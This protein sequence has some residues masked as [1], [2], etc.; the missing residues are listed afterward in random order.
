MKQLARLSALFL[1]AIYAAP[2][3]AD[4][5]A[6]APG[7]WAGFVDGFMALLKLLAS[8]LIQVALVDAGAHALA[9]DIGYYGGVLTFAASAAAA[10]SSTENEPGT[11]EMGIARNPRHGLGMALPQGQNRAPLHLQKSRQELQTAFNSRKTAAAGTAA[12]WSRQGRSG[13]SG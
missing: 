7:F 10:A 2:A 9:Y 1:F 3:L 6:Y 11:P 4:T 12:W 13:R 8:P 5:A